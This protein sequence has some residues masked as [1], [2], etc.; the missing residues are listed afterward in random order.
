MEFGVDGRRT[1]GDGNGN[2]DQWRVEPRFPVPVLAS[3]SMPRCRRYTGQ[4]SK[5]INEMRLV[6]VPKLHR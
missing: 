6:E 4:F 3:R 5:L 1:A 2:R